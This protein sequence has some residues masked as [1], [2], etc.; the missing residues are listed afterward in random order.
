MSLSV[1]EQLA[2]LEQSFKMATCNKEAEKI[3]RKILALR[4]KH[5]ITR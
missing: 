4:K 5:N 3:L 2:R 1:F